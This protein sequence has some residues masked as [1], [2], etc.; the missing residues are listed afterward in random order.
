MFE[1]PLTFFV[2][3]SD[4][5]EEQGEEGDQR[6]FQLHHFTIGFQKPEICADFWF[7]ESNGKMVQLEFSLIK[8]RAPHGAGLVHTGL[9]LLLPV[10]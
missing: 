7:L 8:N 10:M 4:T 6:K 1:F 3:D 5:E 2:E 9:Y